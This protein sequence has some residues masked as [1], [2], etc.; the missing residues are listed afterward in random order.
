M[1]VGVNSNLPTLIWPFAWTTGSGIITS[2]L[3]VMPLY[4][5]SPKTVLAQCSA[6][7]LDAVSPVDRMAP[8]VAQFLSSLNLKSTISKRSGRRLDFVHVDIT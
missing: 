6:I 1:W 5:S 2:C 3:L 8:K 7:A 4:L